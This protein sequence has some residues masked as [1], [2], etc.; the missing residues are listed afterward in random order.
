MVEVGE[1]QWRPV[2]PALPNLLTFQSNPLPSASP[3]SCHEAAFSGQSIFPGQR[4]TGWWT[5]L[6][7]ELAEQAHSGPQPEGHQAKCLEKMGQWSRKRV[8][9]RPAFPPF[10]V[11]FPWGFQCVYRQQTWEGGWVDTRDKKGKTRASRVGL[12]G[13]DW[14]LEETK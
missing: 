3:I 4:V 14:P 12:G 7:S 2:I 9:G 6:G 5:G 13:T 1:G 8:N 11:W 10:S